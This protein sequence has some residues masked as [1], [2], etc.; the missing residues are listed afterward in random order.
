LNGRAEAFGFGFGFGFGYR[1]GY[2]FGFGD[3]MAGLLDSRQNQ[4]YYPIN[5][6]VRKGRWV[7]CLGVK[8]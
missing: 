1:Y 6:A 2:G 5:T 8:R 3:E 7:S 4:L